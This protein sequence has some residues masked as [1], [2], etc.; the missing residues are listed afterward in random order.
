MNDYNTYPQ[1]ELDAIQAS[2]VKTPFSELTALGVTQNP[3]P[4]EWIKQRQSGRDSLSYV[5]G[6][7]VIRI[8]NKAFRNRWSFI[9]KETRVV[10]SQ[11][12]EKKGYNGAPNTMEPQ[13]SVIQVLG[14]LTVPGWGIREQWGAQ[15]L[16]GGSS[17]QEHAFKSAATDS[18]KKCAS[19]FGVA[20][21]LYGMTGAEQLMITPDD[22]LID[23]DKYFSNLKESIRRRSQESTIP[24]AE[25]THEDIQPMTDP[26]QQAPVQQQTQQ[27]PVQQ[28]QPMETMTEVEML[29]PVQQAPIQQAAEPKVAWDVEDIV[30][31]KSI[32]EQLGITTN[33]GLNPYVQ[34]F[35]K[36]PD[37]NI[38]HHIKPNNIK[39][40]IV[41]MQTNM[42]NANGQ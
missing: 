15:I 8:L 26:T 14:Q 21:D 25:P 34:Q 12:Y 13:G 33:E 19:M 11:D 9:I 40:F 10:Q 30:T 27:A 42:K 1:E 29:T 28:E 20:L 36:N 17:V 23:D 3:V 6:D 7:T 35:M 32:K 2:T 22:F 5:S 38:Q 18:M 37:A 16:T 24:S 41:F 4:Q 39:D 31:L